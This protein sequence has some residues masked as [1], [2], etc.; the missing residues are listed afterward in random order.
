MKSLSSIFFPITVTAVAVSGAIGM[1]P[2]RIETLS[3]PAISF[4]PDTVLYAPDGYKQRR[5]ESQIKE[6][7]VSDTLYKVAED[8]SSLVLEDEIPVIAA[9]DTMKAPDSLRF[10]D[11]FRYKYYAAI[12]DSLT[13]VK[14]RDSLR[15]SSRAKFQAGDS[16]SAAMDSLDWKKLDSIYVADST[17][18]AKIKFEQWYASLS[19]EA[20]KKYDLE[21]KAKLKLA[22][23][24]SMRIVKEERQALKDSLIENTP[25]ILETF[26]VVD[27]MQYKRIITWTV[28][29]DFH[30][31]DA[32]EPDTSYNY[33]FYDYPFQRKDVNATWL[34]VAGSPTQYYNYFNRTSETDVEFYKAQESWSFSP[35]TLP[36]INT[37][38]PYT[39][40]SYTG[41]L[42]GDRNKE[43]DN[44]HVLTTQNI[45]PALNVGLRFDRFGGGGILDREDTKN[46][47]FA[48]Q[49]N[50]LGKRYLMHAGYI[51]NKV[52]RQENGGLFDLSQVRDTVL[53]GRDM[54][55]Y[56]DNA[57][58]TIK[59]HSVFVDQQLRIPFEFLNKIKARR[60]TSFHYD[61]NDLERDITTA[62][63]GHS[64]ELST[65]TRSYSD[66]PDAGGNL[67]DYYHNIFNYNDTASR[68]SMRVMHLDNKV[69]I[70]LQPW[71]SES[72]VSKLNVGIGDYLR[73][74]Y[75]QK[76]ASNVSQNSAYL[77]AGAEGQFKNYFNWNASAKT[78]FLGHDIGNFEVGAN[79]QFNIYPFRRA[80]TSPISFNFHFETSLKNP[81]FYEQNI[82]S[83]HFSWNNDFAKISTTKLQGELDI[84]YW[85]VNA[86][87]G[88][89][90][91]GNNLYYDNAGI[92]QQNNKAMSVLS[93][94]LRKEFVLGPLH[95][96]N[97]ILF[98]TSSNQEVV[99]VPTLALNLKY[100][101]QF[102]VQKDESKTRNILV[103]QFGINGLY[104][105]KWNTPAWNPNLGVFYNQT[106][107]EY[108]NGPIFDV[109]LNAQWKRCCIFIKYQNAT[110]GLMWP[111][112]RQ[113]Y[114][115]A[116]RNI[117]T[118]S[119]MNGLKI[120]IFWPFYMLPGRG[121]GR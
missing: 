114:F 70:K 117:I 60:D 118:Q 57:Q 93:A 30:R 22:Q 23:A 77:Y 55:I 61:P 17:I 91:L 78:V 29:Q 54:K 97:N 44:I 4:A 37:K 3:V 102:V 16:L 47:T 113:D 73:V 74:F 88:Y 79:A 76:E 25:R 63:I 15:Q 46:N 51:S 40:L 21:Q 66:V 90:L 100:F 10:T 99:P 52:I 71:G 32:H 65:Y 81:T 14:T 5:S 41:T 120:G 20:K 67:A 35:S 68:D 48:A 9:R 98:Q 85:K 84:P 42:L 101:L 107:E 34:G 89:A 28:D 36:M 94:S 111:I 109:F 11:P 87:V 64:S 105:T 80:R 31:M 27:S 110:A 72:V 104:N 103:M 43:S 82:Y 6:F 53:D 26:A 13:H 116:D 83:N 62:F 12:L 92:I 59:K 8:T 1:G 112:R 108:T 2:S 119:G 86:K 121:N 58:S 69:F 49:A 95:L 39:E 38:V 56:L 33:H 18:A 115:G 106:A 96:D 45:T 7:A 19:K 75:N 50:Y 24:D